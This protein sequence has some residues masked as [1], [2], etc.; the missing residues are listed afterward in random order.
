MSYGG[1]QSY[2]NGSS[3]ASSTSRNNDAADALEQT[4]F[5]SDHLFQRYKDDLS[6]LLSEAELRLNEMGLGKYKNLEKIIDKHIHQWFKINKTLSETALEFRSGYQQIHV[7]LATAKREIDERD[8]IIQTQRKDFETEKDQYE[9]QLKVLESALANSIPRNSTLDK[10]G[11]RDQ[12]ADEMD[13]NYQLQQLKKDLKE[14]EQEYLKLKNE[15]HRLNEN[16]KIL[17]SSSNS[18]QQTLMNLQNEISKKEDEILKLR[19][20]TQD[21]AEERNGLEAKVQQVSK[22]PHFVSVTPQRQ[23]EY[24]VDFSQFID[25]DDDVS[26][27]AAENGMLLLEMSD[28][29]DINPQV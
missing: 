27:D 20:L 2:R 6:P 10:F 22:D 11:L 9:T 24:N 8:K 1:Q 25:D 29:A 21:L 28:D 7:Q 26:D 12:R 4:I 19:W 14:Q 13:E 17:K 5:D 18:H 15:N 23:M 3:S 16:M